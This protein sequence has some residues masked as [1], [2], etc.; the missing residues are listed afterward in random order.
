MG[1]T[2]LKKATERQTEV[3]GSGGWL[4]PAME[5]HSLGTRY[6]VYARTFHK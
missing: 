2:W 6:K 3:E 4:L 5:G 1:A